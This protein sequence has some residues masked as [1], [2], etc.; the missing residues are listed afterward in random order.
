M[1]EREGHTPS[2]SEGD[3]GRDKSTS[4]SWW[5]QRER[6]R[7]RERERQERREL[8]TLSLYSRYICIHSMYNAS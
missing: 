1:H 8:S 7:E 3:R 2:V 5:R 6:K 4:N